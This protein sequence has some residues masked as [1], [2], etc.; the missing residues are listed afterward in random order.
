VQIGGGKIVSATLFSAFAN[1]RWKEVAPITS[2]LDGKTLELAVPFNKLGDLNA[3][4]QLTLEA[5]LAQNQKETARAPSGGP[6]RVT[7]P[8][9][10]PVTPVLTIDDPANDDHGPGA[11]TYPTD[12]V[13]EKQVFDLK[14]FTLGTDDKNLVFRFDMYGPVHNP[15]GS[16]TNLALQTFDVYIDVDH[17]ANSGARLLLPGRNAAVS[18]DDAWDYALW[19]EGWQQGLYQADAQ[20]VPQKL[21]TEVAVVV[22]PAQNRV[23]VRIPRDAIAGRGDPKTWGVVA[24][25]LS[26]DGFPSAGVWRVRDVEANAE[27]FL[28]GGGANDLN[29]TRIIDVALGTNVKTTQEELLSKYASSSN[30]NDLTNP[31]K[32]AQLPMIRAP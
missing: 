8:D 11:Y 21:S 9:L 25:V 5:V 14:Q 31:D 29:H 4:D 19:V 28:F 6:A 26:Q 16:P 15:W 18:A 20:G 32:L 1:N 22:D 12:A 23:T 7:L 17:K 13:F 2:A 27:Q 30:A 3:G 10:Q 24:V